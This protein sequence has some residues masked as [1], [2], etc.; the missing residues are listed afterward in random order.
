[1]GVFQNGLR[2]SICHQFALIQKSNAIRNTVNN[3]QIVLDNA[4]GDAAFDFTAQ[5]IKEMRV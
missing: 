1:M 3:I 5:Q 4:N 2:F